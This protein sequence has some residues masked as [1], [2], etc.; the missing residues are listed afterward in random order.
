MA[1]NTGAMKVL[2]ES[3]NLTIWEVNKTTT[4]E[5][6]RDID[7]VLIRTDETVIELSIADFNKMKEVK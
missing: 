3:E 7:S 5:I 1:N 6:A 2:Y 4:V